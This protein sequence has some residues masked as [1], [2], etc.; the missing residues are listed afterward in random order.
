MGSQQNVASRSEVV[1]NYKCPTKISGTLPKKLGRKNPK[2]LANSALDTAY[3]WKETFHRQTK[4]LVQS[5]MC[6]LKVDIGL[7]S[8]T[9]DPETAYCDPPFVGHYVATTKLRHV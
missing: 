1:S 5:T 7:L 4:M 9:F 3:P 2:F 8:L 6:P